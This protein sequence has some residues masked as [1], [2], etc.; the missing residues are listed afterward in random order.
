MRTRTLILNIGKKKT[1]AVR[2][3]GLNTYRVMTEREARK[4]VGKVM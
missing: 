3:V 4:D 2:A 1:A